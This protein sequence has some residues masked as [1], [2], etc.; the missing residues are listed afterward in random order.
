MWWVFIAALASDA[1]FVPCGRAGLLEDGSKQGIS[2]VGSEGGG[3][4][5]GRGGES[6]E[7][8]SW[9]RRDR[10][11]APATPA[12]CR[13]AGAGDGRTAPL[14]SLAAGN[15]AWLGCVETN[16]SREVWRRSMAVGVLCDRQIK[17]S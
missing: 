14:G 17:R 10:E 11:L 16:R 12:P 1:R 13:G 15:L 7:T 4:G 8:G 5:A 3:G 2:S 9:R 6:D